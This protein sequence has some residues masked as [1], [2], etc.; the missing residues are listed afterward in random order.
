MRSLSLSPSPSLPLSLSPFRS[1]HRCFSVSPS[2]SALSL[3]PPSC[4]NVCQGATAIRKL[5]TRSGPAVYYTLAKPGV[6]EE[7]TSAEYD[8]FTMAVL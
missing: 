2:R 1:L 3:I 5:A 6:P 8:T 7:R 4:L